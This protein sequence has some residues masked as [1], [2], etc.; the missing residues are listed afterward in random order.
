[1]SSIFPMVF[2]ATIGLFVTS[3]GAADS[4]TD[5]SAIVDK[6]AAESILGTSVKD[7]M[8]INIE[9]NDGYYS[10]CNY[11][12][13]AP[14]RLLILRVYQAAAGFDAGQELDHVRATSGLT[15]AISDLGEKAEVASG[16]GSGLADDVTMIYVLKGRT[17]IIVGL[18]GFDEAVGVEKA[19][20]VAQKILEHL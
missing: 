5:V 17:L 14:G 19:K 1:M 9:G 7:P 3:L 20:A 12:S 13:A 16:A 2:A 11:Y 10:K 15:K 8:P 18:R 6:A 4:K